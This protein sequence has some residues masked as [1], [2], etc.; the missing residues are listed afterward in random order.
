[1]TTYL[2]KNEDGKIYHFRATVID[3]VI[4]VVH[5]VFYN[6]LGKYGQGCGTNEAA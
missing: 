1:M 4:D 3:H 6:W 5:G 2:T